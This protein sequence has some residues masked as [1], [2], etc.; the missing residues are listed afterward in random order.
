MELALGRESAVS[1]QCCVTG[2]N[3]V[4]RSGLLPSTDLRMWAVLIRL[5]PAMATSGVGQLQAR[6]IQRKDAFS[7][8]SPNLG[9]SSGDGGVPRPDSVAACNPWPKPCCV[10][11]G[12]LPRLSSYGTFIGD[13]NA[14]SRTKLN[15]SAKCAQFFHMP[16]RCTCP[17]RKIVIIDMPMHR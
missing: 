5:S 16:L 17:A 10:D 7:F 3:V 1:E 9:V 12:K 4:Y 2:D 8:T 13:R 6:S 11:D 14:P 15:T